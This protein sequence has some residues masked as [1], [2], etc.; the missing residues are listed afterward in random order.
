MKPSM[1]LALTLGLLF[2]GAALTSTGCAKKKAP[3]AAV[4]GENFVVTLERADL[5]SHQT[6]TVRE[7]NSIRYTL[8]MENGLPGGSVKVD[9][10]DFSYGIGDRDIGTES[11][12][13]EL[14]ITPSGKG[15]AVVSGKF[16]WRDTSALPE[17]KAWVKGTVHWTGPNASRSTAFDLSTGYSVTE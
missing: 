2:G 6:E 12:V 9:R 14:T 13:P 16:E 8:V 15:N 10:I 11:V 3:E 17:G 4:P 7:F 1:T 5:I